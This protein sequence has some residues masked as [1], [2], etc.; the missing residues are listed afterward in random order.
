MAIYVC[1]DIHGL[2][3][4]FDALL[5]KKINF[6]P[7]KD[8]LYIIGDG[9]DRCS[10]GIAILQCIMANSNCMTLLL[11]NHE[12]MMRQALAADATSDDKVRWHLNG[13][14]ETQANFDKLSREEQSKILKFL[15]DL[16][17]RMD[18]TVGGRKFHLT[19]GWPAE[20]DF[21]RVWFGPP[22][23]LESPNPL[24]D[25]AT[26]IV[27]HTITLKLLA[28]NNLDRPHLIHRMAQK[29]ERLT[30]CKTDGFICIDCGCGHDF[31][32]STYEQEYL[33]SQLACLRLDDMAEFYVAGTET[34]Y[35]LKKQNHRLLRR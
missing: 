31:W 9:I 1:S 15:E 4:A 25:D 21:D 24:K 10:D 32:S 19:H 7:D 8:H 28:E 22:Q 29:G 35:P 18:V 20:Q 34:D 14:A 12:Y 26:L 23:G 6:N 33:I 16:P 2:K 30:I 17:T 3:H 11:G 27:G 5:E 13:G